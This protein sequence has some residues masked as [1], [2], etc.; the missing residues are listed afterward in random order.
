MKTQQ[1]FE[2]W[3]TATYPNVSPATAWQ[4]Q[5]ARIDALENKLAIAVEA[6]KLYS[7][8]NRIGL[9]ATVA[10]KLIEVSE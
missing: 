7:A 4:H 8:N 2:S 1:Q 9:N 10:L 5:Q 6:L 3:V